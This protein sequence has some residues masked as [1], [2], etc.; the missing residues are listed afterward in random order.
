MMTGT[1]YRRLERLEALAVP[2]D[3][4]LSVIQAYYVGPDGEETPGAV[5]KIDPGLGPND[6]QRGCISHARRN[7]Y[8]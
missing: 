3:E 4:D 1:P 6:G 8:R 5:F 2:Q 7:P